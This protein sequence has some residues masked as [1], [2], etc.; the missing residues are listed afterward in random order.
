M[1]KPRTWK[2]PFKHLGTILAHPQQ[3]YRYK[4]NKAAFTAH[5]HLDLHPD[6]HGELAGP[7]HTYPGA[8]GGDARRQGVIYPG[9]DHHHTAVHGPLVAHA[10]FDHQ[11]A[12][13]VNPAQLGV[14]RSTLVVLRNEGGGPVLRAAKKRGPHGDGTFPE[15]GRTQHTTLTGGEPVAAAALLVNGQ[16]FVNSGHYQ[17]DGDA[18]VKLAIHGKQTGT[19]DRRVTDVFDHNNQ[20]EDLSLKRR[21]Q[22]VSNWARNQQ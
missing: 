12:R 15:I 11:Q 6:Y 9:T 1:P 21:M 16:V 5:D 10:P 17:P 19:L 18:A 8:F 13:G 3:Y 4:T 2:T 7:L 14:D 20:Q 22:T